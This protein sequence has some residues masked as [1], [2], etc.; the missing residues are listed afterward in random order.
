MQFLRSAN[1]TSITKFWVFIGRSGCVLYCVFQ[2]GNFSNPDS[3]VSSFNERS[4]WFWDLNHLCFILL[5][6]CFSAR[7][8]TT[9]LSSEHLVIFI[10][11]S[12]NIS[13]LSVIICPWKLFIISNNSF[14]LN[15]FT[16]M[17]ATK[18]KETKYLRIF[19]KRALTNVFAK[20]ART[21]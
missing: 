13:N 15:S 4:R 1:L 11:V 9:L 18:T 16:F 21:H 12:S 20:R 3:H 8:N 10:N 6:K 14:L 19:R 2:T 7:H 5:F 17:E